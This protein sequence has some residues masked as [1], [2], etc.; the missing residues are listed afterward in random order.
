MARAGY[1][2][3]KPTPERDKL[4]TEIAA[5]QGMD[6]SVHKHR[7]EMIDQA[8]RTYA[9][10]GRETMDRK[11]II[12]L[13]N[14]LHGEVCDC[15]DKRCQVRADIEEWMFEGDAE[16]MAKVTLKELVAAWNEF[17]VPEETTE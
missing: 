17:Y 7:V 8:L 16:L 3:L 10:Q 2:N 6:A 12:E 14:K 11:Q 5:T 4:F 9:K 15:D 1:T 13:A